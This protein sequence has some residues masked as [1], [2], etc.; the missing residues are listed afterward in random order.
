MTGTAAQRWGSSSG[1]AASA[2]VL[3][4][5]DA[6]GTKT[7]LALVEPEDGRLRTL[8]E[9]VFASRRYGAVE[10]IVGEFL[11]TGPH[12]PIVAACVAVAG[13][14]VDGCAAATNLPWRVDAS[15]LARVCEAPAVALVNDLEATAYAMLTLRDDERHVLHPGT[16]PLLRGNAA[17]VAAGTGLG[18]ALLTFDGASHRAIASE[19]GHAD[20]APRNDQEIALLRYLQ[21]RFGG[22]VSYERILSGPGLHNVYCFLRDTGFAKEPPELRDALAA[23]E[24]P[25]PIIS[26]RGLERSDTLCSE[27]LG[28]FCRV[29]GAEAGNVALRFL[30]VGGVFL[31]GGIAPKI[32]PALGR[33]G[34]ADAYGDKGR[35][36]ALVRSIPVNVCLDPNAA[37]HGA[38]WCAAAAAQGAAS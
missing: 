29:Y 32:L 1:R 20:F 12:A 30:A 37:L 25:V 9:Q 8:R 13:P 19:G 10:E 14:V 31:G 35:L 16:K 26:R 38:A 27:A 33:A 21:P 15:A 11:A 28:L 17:V 24:D 2:G 18:E 7:V 22:H 3:L 36:S 6:G 4:A 34:F 23:A 5:G